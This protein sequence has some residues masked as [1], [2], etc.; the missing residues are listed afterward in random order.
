MRRQRPGHPGR[1]AV[2]LLALALIAIFGLAQ[3]ATAAVPNGPLTVA[4]RDVPP[5]AIRGADGGWTGI[6]IDLWTA[7]A[8]RLDLDYHFI[9]LPLAKMI[10]RVSTGEVDAVVAAL[11]IT[12]PRE[13]RVDFSHPFH[14]SGLGIAVAQRPE[15]GFLAT[16]KR[17]FSGQF[18]NTLLALLGLLTLI[19]VLIWLAERR[20][21][22]QFHGGPARGIG[23]GL[24]WS[25]VT[26][27]T[28]GYGD[29]APITLL[30][31]GVGMIWM[32]ASV[33]VI[34]SF[35]AAIAT[36]LTVGELD[37][38]VQ[39]LH[40]LYGARVVTVEGSTSDSFLD[41]HRVRHQT[42]PTLPEA[43][44]RLA[45]G[46]ADAVLYD[47]PI[48]RYLT[49]TRYGDQLRVLPQE[50]QRQDYGIALPQGSP[51]REPINRVLLEIVR[52]ADWQ[53][54]LE[55]YLGARSP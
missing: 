40:D 32:F 13:E 11:T 54:S 23:A 47:A 20:R 24:W 9:E 26:M 34:S 3:S 16:M 8:E 38:G 51:L 48:L 41:Y 28:V 27:T 22:T 55:R 25:A 6:S 49:R 53:P 15:G 4:T 19:G 2:F 29:K 1:G 21:N 10:D 50:L 35:T 44:E 37:R 46:D 39:N 52:S 45:S 31:R 5:F 12:S 36:A 43:L 33:I 17:L 18:L 42:L 30:G 7:I 14:S